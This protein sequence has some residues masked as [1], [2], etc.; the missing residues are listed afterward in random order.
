[1]KH[2]ILL[3]AAFF[4]LCTISCK[5]SD[6]DNPTQGGSTSQSKQDRD[7]D[8]ITGD[9]YVYH[10]PVIFHV[11][12][13]DKK[14]ITVSRLKQILDNVNELYQGNV[15]NV[16]TES[17][18][19]ENIHVQFEL[20]EKDENGNTLA[21]PGVE[22]IKYPDS[23][24]SIDCEKFMQDKSGKYVKYIW[25]PNDY[26]NVMVYNFKNTNADGT[27]L[28]I[29]NLPFKVKDY[30]NLKGLDSWSK[31][32]IKKSNLKFAY[33][34]SVNA[35]YMGQEFEGT[36]YTDDKGKKGYTYTSTDPNATLAHELGHYLGLHHS[37]TELDTYKAYGETLSNPVDS[38]QD[39]DFC[40]DTPSYNRNEYLRW[41]DKYMNEHRLDQSIDMK[42]VV[43][44][45]NNKG[46]DWDADNIMD[47]MVC[48]SFRFTAKQ[49]ERMRQ[50]LYYSP[51]IPGPK[52]DRNSTRSFEQGE[53][54]PMD[55]PIRLAR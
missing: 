29:S 32:P 30:P 48:Y 45:S 52:K 7:S 46:K 44:R 23:E 49:K 6:L 34:V 1:M 12:Y 25:D 8:V 3:L 15:Y 37:F 41:F 38:C 21:T 36:R 39:T 14:T 9:D 18:A 19:S 27:T 33:C 2:Y 35:H 31:Y 42:D 22:Y 17:E 11:F 24:D 54:G 4:C 10:L 53:D 28:G 40:D 20:A 13:K 26:I 5:D 47:Y 55:L 50:V 16:N 43:K 51:L